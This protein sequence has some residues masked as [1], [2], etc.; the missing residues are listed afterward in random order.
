MW[1]LFEQFLQDL[2]FA[3]RTMAANPAFTAMAV[4]S[5]ALGIG[6][7]TGIYSFMDAILMSS[8]PVQDPRSLVMFNWHSKDY[9]AVAHSLNGG[10]YK[11]P[12]VGMVSG[13]FPY[14]A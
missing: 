7:N 6:A 5:L 8:L 4:L 10:T 13:N 11:D 1:T 2:R 3:W 12:G 14:P 9:P